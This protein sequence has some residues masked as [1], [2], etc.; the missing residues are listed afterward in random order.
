MV[1]FD[2]VCEL[3]SEQL[4]VDKKTIKMGTSF[5]ELNADSLDVV[6]LM[7]AIEEEFNIGEIGDNA[8]EHLHTVGDVVAFIKERME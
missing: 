5:D 8:M 3:M 6:E 4:G 7:M 1:V 2:K